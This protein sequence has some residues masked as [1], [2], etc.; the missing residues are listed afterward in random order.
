[1]AHSEI[2][3]V[4]AA[5]RPKLFYG[6]VIAAASFIVQLVM[7]GVYLTSGVFLNPILAEF[8]WT[9]AALSG[10]YTIS[11][12]MMG[13]TSVVA[14]RLNDRF[15][16]RI[17][18]MVSCFLFG[19]AHLMMS[20]IDSVWQLY[21][22]YFLIG[23]GIGG[24]TDVVQLSTVARWF[25][26]ARGKMTA[27]VKVGTGIG[28]FIIP[29][30]TSWLIP[31]FGWRDTY[32][33]LGAMVMV[34]TV[35]ISLLM[36]R[37][38]AMMK[39]VAYGADTLKPGTFAGGTGMTFGEG[40]HTKQ[41]WLLCGA[42]LANSLCMQTTIFHITPH[43]I[44][45][46]ISETSAASLISVMGAVSIVGRLTMGATGDRFGNRRA[47]V[48]CFIA[49]IVSLSWLQ[50][51]S[52][53]WMLYVFILIYGFNHGGIVTAISPTVAELFGTRAMG[54][55]FGIVFLSGTA[56]GGFGPLLAGYIFDI[57]NSYKISFLILLVFAVIGLGLSLSI[58]PIKGDSNGPGRGAKIG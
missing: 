35:P 5:A 28:I 8:P 22:C 57:T 45:L 20:R 39:Q 31:V 58:K 25:V 26:T 24:G 56:G 1:M 43:A 48:I 32:L 53:L 50:I 9:R 55:L 17:V 7:Y 52:S 54:T 44:S 34:T 29:L 16:P 37:D 2:T 40:V 46:G 6:Y 41:F 14:G 42:F 27:L 51:G 13:A 33:V 11:F 49:L 12:V 38:P 10:A 4:Q 36:R 47:V 15:G 19:L 30:V 18:T 21:V 23:V 3:L